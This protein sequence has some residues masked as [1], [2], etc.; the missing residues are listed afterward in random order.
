[1][2]KM[3]ILILV[4]LSLSST[5]RGMLMETDRFA[6][7]LP[8]VDG[9]T[10]VLID[11]DNTLLEPELM[12]GS[13]NWCRY[14]RKKVESLDLDPG[15]QEKLVEAYWDFLQQIIP[16]R[17]VDPDA[18]GVI[19]QIKQ[20]GVLIFGFTARS[21]REMGHTNRQ[22]EA[23]GVHFTPF[24]A[25]IFEGTDS[26]SAFEQGIVYC[27]SSSKV[28]GLIA[29]LNYL[30]QFDSCCV[31]ETLLFVDDHEHHVLS[32]EP[33]ATAFNLKYIGVHFT[34]ADERCATFN[35]AV[36]EYQ[37]QHLPVLISDQEAEEKLART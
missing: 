21:K 28:E 1:M 27:G 26:V 11:L 5:A 25:P 10:L 8:L 36:A 16:V 13:V 6:E 2:A 15:A 23:L 24:T 37:W 19:E 22:L 33:V 7:I 30:C 4:V 3:W 17:A 20:E 12:L 14:F 18:I 29:L 32:L 9:A 34:G 31:P 35:P